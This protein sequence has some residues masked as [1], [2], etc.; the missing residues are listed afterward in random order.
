MFGEADAVQPVGAVGANTVV[1]AAADVA[2]LLFS[3]D[4][5]V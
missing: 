3:K 5:Q 2:A 4:L 1:F